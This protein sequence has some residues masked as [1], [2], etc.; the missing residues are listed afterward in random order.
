M[1]A[2]PLQAEPMS[3]TGASGTPSVQQQFVGPDQSQ[4]VPPPKDPLGRDPR[5]YTVKTDPWFIDLTVGTPY[6]E[7]D[8]VKKEEMS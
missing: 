6:Q 8:E 5:H 7:D 2:G 4:S 3:A 1:T